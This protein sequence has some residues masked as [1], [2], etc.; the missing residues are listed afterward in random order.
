[1]KIHVGPFALVS[2]WDALNP[3]PLSYTLQIV[4]VSVFLTSNQPLQMCALLRLCSYFSTWTEG[5]YSPKPLVT[6]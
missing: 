3:P 5:Q 1:M 6:I 4:S 2:P